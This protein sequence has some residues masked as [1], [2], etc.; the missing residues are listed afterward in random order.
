VVGVS[1]VAEPDDISV[2]LRFEAA[3]ITC[4]AHYMSGKA[5]RK[6]ESAHEINGSAKKK[7]RSLFGMI[8]H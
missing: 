2:Y 6:R 8:V 7:V 5:V 4:I 3:D 1:K